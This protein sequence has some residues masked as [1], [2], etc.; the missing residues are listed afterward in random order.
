MA[1][2]PEAPTSTTP[3]NPAIAA[4]PPAAAPQQ[5]NRAIGPIVLVVVLVILV[6]AY[7]LARAGMPLP[8]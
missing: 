2:A 8:F 1:A 5:W 3:A 7:L 4:T 6:I